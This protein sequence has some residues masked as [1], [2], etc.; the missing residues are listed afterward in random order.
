M[1]KRKLLISLACSFGLGAACM[2]I[3][4]L[5]LGFRTPQTA[6]SESGGPP[7][8]SAVFS[9]RWNVDISSCRELYSAESDHTAFG[10]GDRYCILTGPV[11]IGEEGYNHSGDVLSF[12]RGEG[13]DL[14]AF[15]F[16]TD[17]W[18]QLEVPSDNRFSLSNASWVS[19]STENNSR[20]LIVTA[21]DGDMTYIA[22]QIL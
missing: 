4:L 14:N 17:V 9:S 11:I 7:A 12:T 21:E 3:V 5:A 20:I 16:L 1:K 8:F 10:E 6:E 2:L 18:N 19:I 15:W 22:E 13:S